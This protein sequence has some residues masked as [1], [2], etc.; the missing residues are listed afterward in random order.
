MST[1]RALAAIANDFQIRLMFASK[2]CTNLLEYTLAVFT[3][4]QHQHPICELQN[5]NAVSECA[6]LKW[7]K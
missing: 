1:Q 7:K 3:I 2:C 6:R 5:E 4:L